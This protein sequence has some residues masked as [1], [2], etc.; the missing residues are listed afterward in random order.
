MASPMFNSVALCSA[1]G[2]D[3]PASPRPRVYFETLPGVDGE[4]VQ[5]HGRA[6]RQ[7]QVRGVL[8]AQ[9]ATPDLACAA[10]KTLLRARQ[11]LADGAT[12]AAYVGADGTA[13]SNCLLLSYG[14]AGL[15]SVSP[16]P[17]GYR[18]VLRVQALVRQLTP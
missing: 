11:E 14:P 1:A 5:A 12:V 7:V 15:M 3:A 9:A 2:A 4:Y 18:A 16:R 17:T 13:Y 10:L 8:A 6:G